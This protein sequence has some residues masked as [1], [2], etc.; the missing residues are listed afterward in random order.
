MTEMEEEFTKLYGP[1][2]PRLPPIR[3][4]NPTIQLIDLNK[5]YVTR[6]PKC[7]AA[8][9]PLLREKMQCYLTVGWAG[10]WKLADKKNPIPLLSIPKAGAEL[11]LRTVIDVC[12]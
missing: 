5:K 2:P 10:W 1:P 8:L 9:F 12:E 7:S 11:K 4:V 6:P 3:E